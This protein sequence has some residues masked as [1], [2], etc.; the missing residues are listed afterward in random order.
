MPVS[1]FREPRC[2][3]ND[4][5]SFHLRADAALTVRWEHDRGGNRDMPRTSEPGRSVSSR[6]LELLFCF[7]PG[8]TELNLA[9]LVRKTGLPRPTVRRLVLEL[10]QAGALDRRAD[11]RFSVGLKLW[12]LG[13]LAP[14]TE[15]LRAMARPYMEDLYSALHQHVQLAVLEGNEA[16]V[17]ERLSAP[18]A[19]EL[20][21]QVGGRLPLHCSG[22][23]KIL[24]SHSGPDLLEEV[25]DRC[26]QRFTSRTVTDP[27][28]LR[29]E[30]ANCRRTG[31]AL[32]HGELTDGADSIAARIIDNEGK[33]VAA[34]SVVFRS[35]SVDRQAILPAVITCALAISRMLGWRPG[36]KVREGLF[37]PS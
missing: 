22:V 15:S 21:S 32:V 27:S 37:Q 30:L 28:T 6:L 2:S 7:E 13:T 25:L 12:R 10:T 26:L 8:Q 14:L 11:G 1:L 35:G 33:V 20:M 3:L 9:E 5:S 19:M 18:Q 31:T 36:V 4:R 29:K 24:L 16:V 34:L 23:G 17:I